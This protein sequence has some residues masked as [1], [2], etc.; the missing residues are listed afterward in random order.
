MDGNSWKCPKMHLLS[1]IPQNIELYGALLNFDCTN[2]EHAL[3][4]FAKD[5]SKAVAKNTTIHEFDCI[6]A[7]RLQQHQIQQ[8]YITEYSMTDCLFVKII[9]D[10][11]RNHI[12]CVINNQ[13][14][15]GKMY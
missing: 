7:K 8:R 5:L 14:G 9:T 13:I 15:V 6:L 11:K 10:M 3:Q 4:E 1:H 2:G 12:S